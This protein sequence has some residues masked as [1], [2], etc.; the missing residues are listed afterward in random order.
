MTQLAW[1]SGVRRQRSRDDRLSGSNED[2]Y[3]GNEGQRH[4]C[5]VAE[6]I[7]HSRNDERLKQSVDTRAVFQGTLSLHSPAF[8]CAKLRHMH[9]LHQS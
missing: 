8:P 1:W 6:L 5:H 7:S 9:I 3:R 4:F 2:D